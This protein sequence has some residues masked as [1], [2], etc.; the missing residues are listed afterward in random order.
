MPAQPTTST[1][2]LEKLSPELRIKVFESVLRHERIL[3]YASEGKAENKFVKWPSLCDPTLTYPQAEH[4]P[5][6]G[7]RQ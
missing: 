3:V 2:W 4:I 6:Y 7:T 1:P 5:S